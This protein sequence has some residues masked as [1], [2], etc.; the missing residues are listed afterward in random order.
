MVRSWLLHR[1]EVPQTKWN[2][3]YRKDTRTGKIKNRAYI[4]VFQDQ[5][6]FKPRW[7]EPGTWNLPLQRVSANPIWPLWSFSM[8]RSGS[9]KKGCQEV[10]K[11]HF[12]LVW[13]HVFFGYII[14]SCRVYHVHIH[15]CSHFH[16]FLFCEHV[17]HPVEL[18]KSRGLYSQRNHEK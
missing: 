16:G 17:D 10:G 18:G 12:G 4:R 14:P 2:P 7:T 6:P 5:M 3:D 8:R 11:I 9:E 1:Y 13:K 15:H